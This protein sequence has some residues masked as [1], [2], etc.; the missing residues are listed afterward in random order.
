MCNKVST[1]GARGCFKER[2]LQGY[3]AHEKDAPRRTLLL[4]LEYSRDYAQGPMVAL[5][6]G[7]FFMSEVLLYVSTRLPTGMPCKAQSSGP[8][9]SQIHRPGGNPGAKR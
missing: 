2:I 7:H 5:G 1:K 8:M 6:G 4:L 3:L 9:K